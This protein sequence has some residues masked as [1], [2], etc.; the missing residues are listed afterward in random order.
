MDPSASVDD[1]EAH[2]F[3]LLQDCKYD[4]AIELCE[5]LEILYSERAVES[6]KGDFFCVFLAL[7]LI[8]NDLDSVRHLWKRAPPEIKKVVPE[9]SALWCIG[10]NL[11]L[12][13][14]TGLC[15]ALSYNCS[16]LLQPL[17]TE[18]RSSIQRSTVNLISKSY[19]NISIE[20]LSK[21]LMIS[22]EDTILKCQELGWNVDMKS[23]L[24]TVGSSPY[25]ANKSRKVT[26]D[27][28]MLE[29]LSQYVSH[30]E[31][32]PIKI[33]VTGKSS[34]GKDASSTVI[35]LHLYDTSKQEDFQSLDNQWIQC[36]RKINEPYL[37]KFTS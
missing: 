13:N 12:K 1:L 7:Y 31:K 26:N 29:R 21:A 36:S 18:I 33:D 17:L 9:F 11:L 32:K 22:S 10:K 14:T 3:G 4:M 15:D 5:S 23:S 37:K 6:Q 2:L 16:A 25:E 20:S 34:E 35:L 8:V 24:V 27:L 19:S 28:E 30:L